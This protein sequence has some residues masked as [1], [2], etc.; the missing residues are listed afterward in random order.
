MYNASIR[1][2]QG[3]SLEEL[4]GRCGIDAA[5]LSKLERGESNATVQTLDRVA[6]GLGVSM[7]ELVDI[8]EYRTG[9][10]DENAWLDLQRQMGKLNPQQQGDILAFI[11]MVAKWE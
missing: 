1:M 2:G 4:S 9:K 3:L 5:P 8:R 6:K 10:L 7:V 11:R